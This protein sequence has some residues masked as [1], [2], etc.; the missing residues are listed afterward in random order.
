M[1]DALWGALSGRWSIT[2]KLECKMAPFSHILS[3][4]CTVRTCTCVI[5]DAH[6]LHHRKGH[7]NDI[8][9]Y[10][11]VL[12]KADE[13][14]LD[15]TV[16]ALMKREVPNAIDR[17]ESDRP[18]EG[19]EKYQHDIKQ[20]NSMPNA[21]SV[22]Q[23]ST[24]RT[25]TR[26]KN[27]V[28]KLDGTASSE[29][30]TEI[31][32]IRA[33]EVAV[34]TNNEQQCTRWEIIAQVDNNLTMD[35]LANGTHT[36]DRDDA[37]H[38][39]G[40]RTPRM[41]L[42]GSD[43]VTAISPVPQ[44]EEQSVSTIATVDLQREE[45]S[46]VD[47]NMCKTQTDLQPCSECELS[48]NYDET[49][50][51][52]EDSPLWP[53][54]SEQNFDDVPPP[55]LISP[56]QHA[57]TGVYAL[58]CG[59]DK[60]SVDSQPIS[61][62]P[63]Q[64][65]INTDNQ[66]VKD[67]LPQCCVD[68]NS[69]DLLPHG[70]ISS[71]EQSNSD[72]RR[73]GP[74]QVHSDDSSISPSPH[75]T[76]VVSP[77][78]T[79][80]QSLAADDGKG[81]PLKQLLSVPASLSD[82]PPKGETV[83][84]LLNENTIDNHSPC[85]MVSSHQQSAADDLLSD[86]HSVTKPSPAIAS[87]SS[88]EQ[89]HQGDQ[90][91][92]H[93]SNQDAVDLSLRSA[94]SSQ[95]QLDVDCDSPPLSEGKS[96]VNFVA[97]A[98]Q[99]CP[100]G[101]KESASDT[102]GHLPDTVNSPPIYLLPCVAVSSQK[103]SDVSDQREGSSQLL[104]SDDSSAYISPSPHCVV[105]PAKTM[106]QNLAVDDGKGNPLKQLLSVQTSLSDDPPKGDTVQLLSNEN[107]IDNHSPCTMVFSH[108]QS[109][110]DDRREGSSQHLL[111][112]EH[113]PSPTFS[114]QEQ[115]HQSD[116]SV[117]HQS[118]QDAVDL[119]LCSAIS[120]QQQL[121]VN[122]SSPLLSEGESHVN[123]VASA[124]QSCSVG[125][126]QSTLD[127]NGHLP[128]TSTSPQQSGNGRHK[129]LALLPQP[130][131]LKV[132]IRRQKRNLKHRKRRHC[133]GRVKHSK[134]RRKRLHSRHTSLQC[135]HKQGSPHPQ[136]I[137]D[138]G[139]RPTT[140]DRNDN[141]APTNKGNTDTEKPGCGSSKRESSFQPN[142]NN[143]RQASSPGG[144]SND[145][146]GGDEDEDKDPSSGG[147]SF[148]S[149]PNWILL[150]LIVLLILCF[151]FPRP[152]EPSQRTSHIDAE[153]VCSTVHLCT[154][155]LDLKSS[156]HFPD[157]S[158]DDHTPALFRGA[159]FSKL[160]KNGGE[161]SASS[162]MF[163]EGCSTD[164]LVSEEETPRDMCQGEEL[165][166]VQ[167]LHLKRRRRERPHTTP[168][169]SPRPQ[170]DL[171]VSE[172]SV[173]SMS[174]PKPFTY[175]SPEENRQETHDRITSQGECTHSCDFVD[176]HMHMIFQSNCVFTS[177]RLLCGPSTNVRHVLTD[178]DIYQHQ[179]TP[180]LHSVPN[181]SNAADSSNTTT[182]QEQE[183]DV[184]QQQQEDD[185]PPSQFR[186]PGTAYKKLPDRSEGRTLDSGVGTNSQTQNQFPTAHQTLPVAATKINTSW[187]TSIKKDEIVYL[188]P[189]TDNTVG[190]HRSNFQVVPSVEEQ[191]PRSPNYRAR[192]EL[193]VTE[194]KDNEPADAISLQPV[195]PLLECREY[196]SLL[197]EP[198]M[199]VFP[200]PSPSDES[201]L[202][203]FQDI[204]ENNS[205]VFVSGSTLYANRRPSF[206]VT[207]SVLTDD[208]IGRSQRYRRLLYFTTKI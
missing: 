116:Q 40:T 141:S 62:P 88:Q 68:N 154:T 98:Q 193:V 124:Q 143:T 128:D 83:Q 25:P 176:H 36:L 142:T 24:L 10:S 94:I 9:S 126:K 151:C 130:A 169:G 84:L 82:D 206:P 41:E 150:L 187:R 159:K 33:H 140:C 51:R 107:T 23:V 204:P 117:Q 75:C 27:A 186:G 133:G 190:G 72:D 48:N 185:D 119:S 123:S 135:Y 155:T 137:K 103:Q 85:T 57:D 203:L 69:I 192:D 102:N 115:L 197:L 184:E 52:K 45:H 46:E 106:Q 87:I 191:T 202:N 31:Q 74:S 152:E 5:S 32:C 16:P 37:A 134:P 164:H 7:L 11:P 158:L 77:A 50:D 42:S 101:Q 93:Q 26:D 61:S 178:T 144:S 120:S 145:G 35:A 39:N 92:Q 95:Q 162:N 64:Q 76:C 38:H 30:H 175:P 161:E 166:G 122:G 198:L 8:N 1:C 182:G 81:N 91:V 194:Q 67:D 153:S 114:S 199:R 108:Q 147:R 73:N 55:A 34:G 157:S 160:R 4:T 113:K 112:S 60:N 163:P 174:E 63:K 138:K 201:V 183:E 205:C 132:V 105:S 43:P 3:P 2:R 89:L 189:S 125:Q 20:N 167:K 28:C 207:C 18:Q 121:D 104:H 15:K 79:T 47:D 196:T 181:V 156:P 131:Q 195:E 136:P 54:Q 19:D 111:S 171:S 188:T 53:V 177:S 173:K 110:A 56:Q 17:L 118:N 29:S 148:H 44:T 12:K 200:Y 14:D 168:P 21:S 129:D 70:V 179:Q 165:A 71:P 149:H 90:P 109:G 80:Q 6:S 58:L 78:Q 139:P 180:P 99:S 100:V 22:S 59:P 65:P 170:L 146:G 13:N 49:Y 66:G 172:P 127:T 86:E 97:S 96:H 208:M